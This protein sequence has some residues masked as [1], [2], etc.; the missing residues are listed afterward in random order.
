MSNKELLFSVTASDCEFSYARGT[1]C[2]G[3]A[4][5]RSNNAVHCTHRASGAHG[6]SEASRSQLDN[7]QDAFRKMAESSEFKKWHHLE[8]L[9]R[10]GAMKRIDDIVAEELRRVRVEIK[11]ENGRWVPVDIDDP[12]DMGVVHER[13]D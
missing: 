12:L 7:K 1:G 6:Y 5:N 13:T 2:G 9:R 3:Q 8:T 10:N 4:R 11:D